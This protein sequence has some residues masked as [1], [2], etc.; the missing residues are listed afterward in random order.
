MLGK[1][2]RLNIKLSTTWIGYELIV[3]FPD[4]KIYALWEDTDNY[5]IDGEQIF[6]KVSMDL[7]TEI[8]DVIRAISDY[9]IYTGIKNK[10]RYVL[11]WLSSKNIFYGEVSGRFIVQKRK[12]NKNDLINMPFL[13]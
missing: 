13:N 7:I 4:G 12:F 8:L 5:P 11:V 10:K 3:K 6:Y 2:L 1:N 9:N